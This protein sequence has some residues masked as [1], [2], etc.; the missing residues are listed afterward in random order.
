MEDSFRTPD[1]QKC[2]VRYARE[3]LSFSGWTD[4]R[5]PW[6]LPAVSIP[7][8]P[9]LV[10]MAMG[11]RIWQSLKYS[12][13]ISTS[14][15]A[16]SW[17][18]AINMSDIW[19]FDG[20]CRGS[21]MAELTIGVSQ[22]SNAEMSLLFPDVMADVDDSEDAGVLCTWT[23]TGWGTGV[24]CFIARPLRPDWSTGCMIID[25]GWGMGVSCFVVRPRLN[26]STEA[27]HNVKC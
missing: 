5:I 24:S 8:L 13:Q 3:G 14:N 22:F 23:E 15:A 11:M 27:L 12:H 7:V 18:L 20:E 4:F 25:T 1:L 9:M 17:L 16:A 19:V 6:T 10:H 26:W 2:R 21:L